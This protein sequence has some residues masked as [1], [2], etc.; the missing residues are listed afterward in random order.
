[1]QK[2]LLGLGIAGVVAAGLLARGCGGGVSESDK[3]DAADG[4]P[5]KLVAGV[6]YDPKYDPAV[7]PATLLQDYD[8]SQAGE[9]EWLYALLSGSPQTLN[10]IFS[11]S[12]YESQVNSLLFGGLFSFNA[13]MEWMI[14]PT[15]TESVTESEDHKVWT[16]KMKKGLKWH[17]GHPLTA[18]DVQYSYEQIMDPDVPCPAQKSGTDELETVRALDEYT[19]QFVHKEPLPTSKWNAFFPVIPKHLFEKGKAEDKTL[20]QSGYYSKLNRL[21]VGSGPYK[22]L[23]WKQN[24][25][26]VL[27]RWEEYP[28]PKPHF[29][30]IVFKIVP[31]PNVR[32]AVFE[33]G[34]L[35]EVPLTAKQFASETVT[36]AEFKKRG[37]KALSQA[38]SY[39]YI[40]WN[41]HDNPFFGDRRVRHAMT[42]ALDIKQIIRTLQYDLVSRAHGIYHPESWMYN[43][44]IKLLEY[45]LDRSAELLDEAGWKVSEDD[46]W[47]YKDGVKFSFTLLIPQGST[48]GRQLAAILQQDLKSLGVELKTRIMEWA[49]F[50]QKT[51]QCEFQAM[52][53]GWGTGVDPD[54]NWNLWRTEERKKGR[55]YTGFSNK[56]VDELFE[57][58]RRE[59][60]HAK[61]KTIYQ[62]I[63]KIIYEEQPYTFL[64]NSPVLRGFQKRIR[65]IQFSPRGVWGFDPAVGAWWVLK[66]DQLHGV[67]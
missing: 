19:I 60:D 30:R 20:K 41:L 46:G 3:G 33:K 2:L 59:F 11:S 42:H 7:N 17:D 62:E 40:G 57:M 58:G 45:D 48:T 38:W 1:M 29:K 36:S 13:A 10:P 39:A 23:E 34:E 12:V 18:H 65:G 9:A 37:Y 53:A 21:P 63:G 26:I 22:L 8:S 52:M 66:G 61:R 15:W 55:N 51:R 64:W 14:D 24:D 47:R 31:D 6:G 4:T 43:P 27:E 35:D 28:G 50:Q 25:K 32:L 67:K 5:G 49:T 54:T 16:V 44:G 56:R